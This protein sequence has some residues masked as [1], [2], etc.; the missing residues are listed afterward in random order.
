M[1][2]NPQTIA[3]VEAIAAKLG[4]PLSAED[5]AQADALAQQRRTQLEAEQLAHEPNKSS[6]AA[7]VERFNRFYPK[8]LQTLIGVGDVMISLTQTI[9]I[10]IGVP[11]VLILLMVVEQQRV[12]RGMELFEVETTLA[13]FGATVL[14]ICNLLFELLISWREHQSSWI[15]P[16]SYEFSFRLCARR[17]AYMFGNRDGWTPA[18]KSP[19]LRFKVVLRIITFSILMLALAGSMHAV[20]ERVGGS[21]YEAIVTVLTRS[22]LLEFT[23]WSGGL[24]FAVA[25]VFAAQALSQYVAQK[26]IEIIAIMQS[27]ASNKPELI[28]TAGGLTAAMY[29]YGRLKESQ[30][31][32]R[33]MAH[34]SDMPSRENVITV[35]S[36]PNSIEQ[37]D[38]W[39]NRTGVPSVPNSLERFSPAIQKAI[40]WLQANPDMQELSVRKAANLAGVSATSM[41]SAKKELGL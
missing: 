33:T 7:F 16:P 9:L 39:G 20:I 17:L 34:A 14:V 1:N 41:H 6:T 2:E 28:A 35:P 32:R 18:A 27:S 11:V 38:N 12:Y 19:A 24:M 23:T 21:W 26:V 4:I 13:A 10:G 15:E 8:F 36:V 37:H 40:D 25:A 3:E 30:R 22:T 5:Y 31:Q 29:L